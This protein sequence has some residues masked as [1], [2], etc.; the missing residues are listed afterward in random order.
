MKITKECVGVIATSEENYSNIELVL[1]RVRD[2]SGDSICV[3]DG[4]RVILIP[5]KNIKE[6]LYIN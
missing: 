4:D 3:H 5:T 6:L 1:T 2:D